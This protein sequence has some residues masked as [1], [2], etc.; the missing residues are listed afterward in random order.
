V[1]LLTWSHARAV[2]VQAM[3]DQHGILMDT[4]NELHQALVRGCPREQL[5][6]HLDR[7]VE[8]S[9]LHFICEEQLLERHE[10][11]GLREH[12]EAHA[13]LLHQITETVDH[14]AHTESL[15]MQSLL[16]FLR[17]WYAEHIEGLDH[18]YGEWLNERGIF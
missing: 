5:D 18:Q 8:F 17:C 9:R 6:A 12:R 4:I 10:F 11:P 15:E 7:L 3:D 1:T 16:S 14:V 2:G 13:Q